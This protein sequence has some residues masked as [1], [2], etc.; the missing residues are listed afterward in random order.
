MENIRIKQTHNTLKIEFLVSGDPKITRSLFVE[1]SKDFFEPLH[2]FATGL[3]AVEVNVGFGIKYINS[4]CSK[5]IFRFLQ[6]LRNNPNIRTI[7]AK[8][9]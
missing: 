1:N 6:K 8:W 5:E 2:T 7:L 4:A 3:Q 9:F